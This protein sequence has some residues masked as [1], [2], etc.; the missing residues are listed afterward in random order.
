M[1]RRN[2]SEFTRHSL[3]PSLWWLAAIFLGP[4]F[5]VTAQ[6]AAVREQISGRIRAQK[7]SRGWRVVA[8]GMYGDLVEV[9]ASATGAFRIDVP[10]GEVW[11]LWA[12]QTRDEGR[13][14]CTA[15]S[16][17]SRPGKSITLFEPAGTMGETRLKLHGVDA[18]G[19]RTLEAV[20]TAK[21]PTH[22]TFVRV[23]VDGDQVCLPFLP[24]A[25][26]EVTIASRGGPCL[27]SSRFDTELGGES[28]TIDYEMPARSEQVIH[29]EANGTA[30]AN[31]NV[32]SHSMRAASMPSDPL[33]VRSIGTTDQTGRIVLD[34]VGLDAPF[35]FFVDAPGYRLQRF[36][37]RTILRGGQRVRV[38]DVGTPRPSQTIA[39]VGDKG[40]FV[41][42]EVGSSMA[43]LPWPAQSREG[44]ESLL[45]D[46]DVCVWGRYANHV[47]AAHGDREPLARSLRP[48]AARSRF[49]CIRV[50]SASS[51]RSGKVVRRSSMTSSFVDPSK[52]RSTF[53]SPPCR[54]R[55]SKE[56]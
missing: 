31:V 23:P 32:S 41:D 22:T 33:Y 11:T 5:A 13:Y 30:L 18:W 43:R 52:D 21:F 28:R 45:I 37:R 54:S 14:A 15:A 40:S 16:W 4:T 19:D 35:G 3:F 55:S 27:Q 8:C 50:P 47:L 26:C 10:T 39:C 36:S 6:V 38:V 49:A 34:A 7:D 44:G 42:Y 48:C 24:A 25:N 2:P 20:L 46:G 1:P 53:V 9:D 12:Y 29:F 51:G 56:S 17:P